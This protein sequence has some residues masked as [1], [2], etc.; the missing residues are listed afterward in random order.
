MG[1]FAVLYFFRKEKILYCQ[2]GETLEKVAWRSCGCS[3]PGAVQGLA[4]W[5]FEIPGLW[6]GDWFMAPSRP[7]HSVILGF[8]H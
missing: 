2:G 6:Q 3:I 8:S 7:N 4:G 1:S 5:G